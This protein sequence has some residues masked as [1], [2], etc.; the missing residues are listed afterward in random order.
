MASRVSLVYG[1]DYFD[2]YSDPDEGDYI[3]LDR[4]IPPFAGEG[5]AVA[6][7]Y[8][9]GLDGVSE[10]ET[11]AMDRPFDFDVRVMGQNP[12]DVENNYRL[13]VAYLN[14]YKEAGEDLLLWYAPDDAPP[15][16]PV[17]GFEPLYRIK[18][19][20]IEITSR[21]NQ[22]SFSSYLDLNITLVIAPYREG[23]H[24]LMLVAS[25]G[26][27]D[28]RLFC[29]GKSSRGI[30]ALPSVTNLFEN[31]LGDYGT[32]GVWAET[33]I[34]VGWRPDE[35]LN[36]FGSHLVPTIVATSGT[37][38]FTDNITAANTNTHVISFYA[39]RSDG[40]AVDAS[41]CRVT[42]NGTG[43]SS[44]YVALPDG[45][46]LVWASVTGVAS[47]VA[48][49]VQLMDVG[50]AVTVTGFMAF[51][52]S[53]PMPLCTGDMPGCSW[54]GTEHVSTSTRLGGSFKLLV[55]QSGIGM[56]TI[57]GSFET[58][59]QLTMR[60]V[61]RWWYPYNQGGLIYFFNDD[62]DDLAA[63]YDSSTQ[64]LYL[65][66]GTNTIQTGTLSHAMFDIDVIHFVVGYDTMRIYIN[67][68]EA[69]SGSVYA[70]QA[71]VTYLSIGA[72]DDN[73]VPID[74]PTNQLTSTIVDLTLWDRVL[75]ATQIANDYDR[76]RYAVQGVDGFGNMIGSLPW[77][78]SPAWS[79]T[80]ATF[81]K[82]L[83]MANVR[84]DFGYI[85]GVGGD[86]WADLV[87]LIS[88]PATFALTEGDG[89]WGGTSGFVDMQGTVYTGALN[90]Q[91]LQQ[92]VNT[93]EVAFGGISNGIIVD[94]YIDPE[95][96]SGRQLFIGAFIADAGSDLQVKARVEIYGGGGELDS[97]WQSIGAD[98]T[99]RFF[100]IGPIRFPDAG[101]FVLPNKY[102]NLNHQLSLVFRRSVAG[103][104]NVTVDT[105]RAAVGRVA[106]SSGYGWWKDGKVYAATTTSSPVWKETYYLGDRPEVLPHKTT[107]FTLVHGSVGDAVDT[108][109]TAVYRAYLKPRRLLL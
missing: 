100:L 60:F 9:G 63:Y 80:F 97:E 61:V 20:R 82:R 27:M 79:S 105:M 85:G 83:D 5:Q 86:T 46:Y 54:S 4:F 43:R 65:T 15:F 26:V 34:E 36:I 12:L 102:L 56:G 51:E 104:A 35:D 69:A 68:V 32:S 107:V 106:V 48:A 88:D 109:S 37:P 99:L 10:I 58:I 29:K 11:Y 108:D 31:P 77:F 8:G 23:R 17:W 52:G 41:V 103:S 38:V 62:D 19:F 24:Q 13:L 95:Y 66:D 18:G 55:D 98:T 57:A 94:N 59:A 93:S 45:W 14:L 49:G 87:L 74:R 71:A 16:L 39:R 25:D 6:G 21:F 72:R 1:V 7:D 90:G 42:Y 3:L 28:D 78:W 96:F 33:N 81:F 2:F 101:K 75:S 30:M 40:G 76:V 91:G 70:P 89:T 53:Y 67:G 44:T 92:A 47:S 64:R 73:S 22:Q 50:V 84:S